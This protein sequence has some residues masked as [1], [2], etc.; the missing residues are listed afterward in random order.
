MIADRLPFG[1]AEGRTAWVDGDHRMRGS[2]FRMLVRTAPITLHLLN[3]RFVLSSG[4]AHVIE[5]WSSSGGMVAT[6]IPPA[7]YP[8]E[9]YQTKL[10]W[11]DRT[12]ITNNIDAKQ[13]S[14]M[15]S[16][17]AEIGRRAARLGWQ[18]IDDGGP[19]HC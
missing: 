6:H 16:E 9:R 1:V 11:W 8:S 13:L 3:V 2:L 5:K 12:T 17:L 10:I 19:Q 4:G 18:G 7:P 15:N 14:R